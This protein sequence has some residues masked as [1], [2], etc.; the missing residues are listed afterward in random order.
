MTLK[1]IDEYERYIYAVLLSQQVYCPFLPH[2]LKYGTDYMELEKYAMYLFD[3]EKME[4]EFKKN[5]KCNWSNLLDELTWKNP[6]RI[7]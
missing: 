6:L 3:F 7:L 2:V 4:R 5:R 1:K